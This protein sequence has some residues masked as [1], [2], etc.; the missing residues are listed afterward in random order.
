MSES[1]FLTLANLTAQKYG[2]SITIDFE[3]RIVDFTGDN[4][5][6]IEVACAREI[7]ELFRDFV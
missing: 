7:S 5:V 4:E 2:M 3:R 1:E 6:K